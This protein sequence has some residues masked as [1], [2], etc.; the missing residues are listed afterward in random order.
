MMNYIEV[1]IWSYVAASAA[2]NLYYLYAC[3]RRGIKPL[4]W[5]YQLA[6]SVMWPITWYKIIQTI[7]KQ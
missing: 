4:S 2:T 1:L 5:V 3:N 6:V 7:R